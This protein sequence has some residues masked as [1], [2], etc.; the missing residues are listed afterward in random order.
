MAPT[1]ALACA[2]I[3]LL[4]AACAE[5]TSSE[6]QEARQ[7]V[8]ALA[9]STP[10]I[11]RTGAPADDEPNTL[12]IYR[13]RLHVGRE[14]GGE[15]IRIMVNNA[16]PQLRVTL[17]GN[18]DQDQRSVTVCAVTDETS[19]PP[20]TQCVLPVA[21]RPVD[22]PA[23]AGV[24]GAEIALAGRSTLVDLEEIALT[25]EATDRRVRVLLPNIDP[26][27]EDLVCLPKGCPAFQMAPARAGRLSAQ[28]SWSEP[29]GA[30]LDIRTEVP[31]PTVA[32]SP[33]PPAYRVLSSSTS[34]SNAGPGSVAIAATLRAEQESLLA[35]TNNGTVPL[36]TPVLEATWP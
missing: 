34:S 18:L 4:V 17:K 33:T 30:L 35:L 11:G 10:T 31:A 22:L 29:G 7:E 24:K 32:I 19:V 21:D 14:E 3:I 16:D 13:L 27:A 6:P 26:P 28:A 36:I 15:R 20:S 25:Y 8:G 23:G 12:H 5:G 9:T 2:L 1:R